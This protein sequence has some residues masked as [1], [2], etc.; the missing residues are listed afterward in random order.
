MNE[1]GG[2]GLRDV[3]AMV[4]RFPNEI[5]TRRCPSTSSTGTRHGV[6]Q[7]WLYDATHRTPESVLPTSKLPMLHQACSTSAT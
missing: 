7:M 5:W 1:C 6:S 2:G 4:Q 3:L